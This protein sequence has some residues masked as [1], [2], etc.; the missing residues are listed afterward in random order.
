ASLGHLEW[1]MRAVAA[2]LH[3][4]FCLENR[5][6]YSNKF[7]AIRAIDCKSAFDRATSWLMNRSPWPGLKLRKRLAFAAL[8]LLFRPPGRATAKFEVAGRDD[9]ARMFMLGL[10]D[11]CPGESSAAMSLARAKVKVPAKALV[12]EAPAKKGN[13]QVTLQCVANAGNVQVCAAAALEGEAP[14]ILV[15]L[16][17]MCAKWQSAP[18]DDKPKLEMKCPAAK[19]FRA[20]AEKPTMQQQQQGKEDEVTKL[21]LASDEGYAEAT[22][23][24]LENVA[25]SLQGFPVMTDRVLEVLR[26]FAHGAN[27]APE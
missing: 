15:R 20:K 25:R 26:P 9:Q 21:S 19:F 4:V 17:K 5:G 1:I 10:S 8:V 16:E 7:S 22:G 14:E 12:A 6:K 11:A 23:A 3:P 18:L 24:I 2:A 27:L 13:A